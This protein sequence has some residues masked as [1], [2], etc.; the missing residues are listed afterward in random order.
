LKEGIFS[1]YWICLAI[2]LWSISLCA[3]ESIPVVRFTVTEFIVSGDNPLSPQETRSALSFFLGEHE[4]L[5]G[6]T[7]AARE[8]ESAF[9]AAGHSFHRVTLPQQTLEGGR[10]DLEVVVLTLDNVDVTGNSHFTNEN[11]KASLP[12]LTSGSTPDVRELSRELSIANNHPAKDITLRLKAS[13]QPGRIDAELAVEDERPWQV[14]T[15]LNNTGTDETGE[16]R[17]SGVYQHSN[18]TSHDDSLTLSYTTS[19]GHFDDVVQYGANYQLPIYA[20]SGI[21][22]LYFSGS[23]VDSGR[24]EEVFDVSG[25]GQFFGGNYTH[26]FHNIDNYRHQL[27]V[28]IDDKLF[29]NDIAFLN[30]PIGVDVRSRPLSFTYAGQWRFTQASL[31]FNVDYVH[32]LGGGSKND[33]VTY[34][35]SRFG[36]EQDWQ[37]FRFGVDGT[38]VFDNQ[39]S[40]NAIVRGQYTSEPLISGEQFGLGGANSIRGFDERVATGD[41]GVRVTLQTYTPALFYNI[42][43]LGFVEGGTVS[44]EDVPLGQADS[45]TLVSIGVGARWSW[46]DNFSVSLDYAH[47]V[48]DVRANAASGVNSDK[49]HLNVFYRF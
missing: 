34:A 20:L 41:K 3:Q 1:K 18:I 28:G 47:E 7:E 32:S 29:E 42:R 13:P 21:V 40:V 8:L 14:F 19:P 45:E 39:W 36:A 31:N 12:G 15:I 25:A 46:S 33:D 26:M 23:D 48:N 9:I 24:I 2:C 16:F 4:G 43:L 11:I 49:L 35:L 10:V 5:E 27:I 22:S 30:S 6:L 17:W 37:A 38:Y 44:L